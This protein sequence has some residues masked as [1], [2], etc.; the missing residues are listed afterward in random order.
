MESNYN[1]QRTE[2]RYY[3]TETEYNA[4][5]DAMIN[6]PHALQILQRIANRPIYVKEEL[7]DQKIHQLFGA[8]YYGLV[9]YNFETNKWNR[10]T[11]AGQPIS[12]QHFDTNQATELKRR[13]ELDA[14]FSELEILA[15]ASIA[16]DSE[17]YPGWGK[18]IVKPTYLKHGGSIVSTIVCRDRRTGNIL[19]IPDEWMGVRQQRSSGFT[20]NGF[21]YWDFRRTFNRIHGRT[22]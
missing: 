13:A 18:P 20:F 16:I 1:M 5:T 8:N 17:L 15:V 2:K 21:R 22:K 12:K 6:N 10:N 7:T 14:A 19:P 11:Y 4:L 3:F 9:Y